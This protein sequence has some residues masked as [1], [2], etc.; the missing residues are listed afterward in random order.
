MSLRRIVAAFSLSFVCSL[1]RAASAPQLDY[2]LPAGVTYEAKVPTP[3]SFF[4]FQVGEWHL[5]SHQVFSYLQAVA[6]AAPE[7]VKLE[8]V[9]HTHERKPLA[10]LTIT[11][12]ENHARL[13]EVRREHLALLDP[14]QS[15][16]LDLGRMPVVV[17]LGY[18]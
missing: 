4:G 5:T 1:P 8:V 14:K 17:N 7:R 11:A 2:Y 9:G 18:S 6:A 12:P 10:V 3:E 15:G 16:S 13:E